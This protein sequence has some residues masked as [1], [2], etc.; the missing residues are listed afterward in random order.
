[1]EIMIAL[2]IMVAVS[3]GALLVFQYQNRNMLSQ[4]EITEMNLMAKG[5]SEEMSRTERMAGGVLPPGV[6]GFQ[7]WG[8][9]PERLTVVLNRAGGVDTTRDVSRFY[10][11]TLIWNGSTY[12]NALLLPVRRVKGVFTDSGYIVTT[13]K[14]PPTSYPAGTYPAPVK[15]T[16]IVLPVQALIES[17]SFPGIGTGAMVVADGSWFAARWPWLHSVSTS[18][19]T[20]VYALDSVRYWIRS[21]TIFRRINRND[22]AAYAVGIDSLRIAYMHPNGIWSDS[23]QAADP[24]NQIQKVR[25]HIVLRTR[26]K[27]RGL[28]TANPSTRGYHFQ[29]VET[30]V[31]LRNASTLVNK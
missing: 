15:D 7:V 11:G 26:H 1:M 18:A 25:T 9:G 4:R 14:V 28:E 29:T 2:V 24:A 27:D 16:M 30:E 3:T 21:D 31:A 19:N 6:G 22:S 17:A 12:Q 13:V 5:V 20:F 23:L 10:V 8:A